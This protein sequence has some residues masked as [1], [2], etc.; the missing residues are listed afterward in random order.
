[1][2]IG[3]ELA[4]RGMTTLLVD[5]DGQGSLS[6][7][8]AGPKNYL[9]M[10]PSKTA[11]ALFDI[12]GAE[13]DPRDLVHSTA[14]DN[15][16]LVPSSPMLEQFNLPLSPTACPATQYALAEHL[17]AVGTDFDIVLVDTPPSLASLSWAALCSSTHVCVPLI[18]EDYSAQGIPHI[19]QRICDAQTV[20]PRLELAGFLLA[21]VHR[22]LAVH[23]AVERKL[24]DLYGDQV[25]EA[26]T[27]H[28]TDIKEAT[29]MKQPIGHW[30]PKSAAAAEVR[31]VADELL[32]RLN[33]PVP[34][35]PPTS[36]STPP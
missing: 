28:R 30:K 5:L 10:H 19:M 4:R 15:L 18:P 35:S 21:M 27:Y 22:R 33:L 24:R 6:Q 25:F 23:Q 34:F 11:A 7:G 16:F 2:H 3:G 17:Q 9:Q 12:Q 29:L 31:L 13:P 8:L 1:M 36:R 32:G 20:N 26:R 14:F